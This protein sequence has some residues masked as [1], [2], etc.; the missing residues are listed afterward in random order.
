MLFTGGFMTIAVHNTRP[1]QPFVTL[2]GHLDNGEFT[3]EVMPETDVPYSAYWKNAIEQKVVYIEPDDAE[4]GCILEALKD[5]R[6][7]FDELQEYGAANGGMSDI[8]V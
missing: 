3:A 6:L 1:D 4:L 7:D 8:P 2:F 5:H